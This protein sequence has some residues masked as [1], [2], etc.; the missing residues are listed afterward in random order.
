MHVREAKFQ[1]RMHRDEMD[2]QRRQ[3]EVRAPLAEHLRTPSGNSKSGVRNP[4][5]RQEMD[6]LTQPKSS[7]PPSCAL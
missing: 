2:Y 1:K 3:W 7:N 6:H 5:R 4:Q